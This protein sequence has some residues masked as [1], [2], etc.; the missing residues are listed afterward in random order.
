VAI[1]EQ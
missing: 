1:D